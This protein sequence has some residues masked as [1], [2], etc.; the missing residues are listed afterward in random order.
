M[1]PTW[2]AVHTT[3]DSGTLG[4]KL[5][6]VVI[7]GCDAF[8]RSFLPRLYGGPCGDVGDQA[9]ESNEDA[10]LHHCE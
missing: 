9:N 3:T 4:L 5:M 7:E 8:K 2:D 6:T 10:R 1:G